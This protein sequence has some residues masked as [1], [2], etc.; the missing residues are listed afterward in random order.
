MS[1]DRRTDQ[2]TRDR[3]DEL[4]KSVDERLGKIA[5]AYE[6]HNRKVTWILRGFVA[7]LAVA[8]LVVTYQQKVNSDRADD[9]RNLSQRAAD[10]AHQIQVERARNVRDS[11]EASNKRHDS[12]IATLDKLLARIPREQRERAKQNRAGTV[13]LIDALAPVHQDKRGRSTCAEYARQ[14]VHQK[15]SP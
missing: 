9:A 2:P 1:P 6:T 13:L 5:E 14:Q 3:I 15:A 7:L 10:L 8:A 11:C 12:T 4:T